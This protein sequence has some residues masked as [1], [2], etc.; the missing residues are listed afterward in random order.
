MHVYQRVVLQAS[1]WLYAPIPILVKIRN[2]S[3]CKVLSL[4]PIACS[5]A[6]LEILVPMQI[7]AHPPSSPSIPSIAFMR[8]Y[9]LRSLA[10]Q[11]I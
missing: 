8:I 2:M 11:I 1:L 5:I 7:L 6:R 9:I 10:K 3:L 4:Y